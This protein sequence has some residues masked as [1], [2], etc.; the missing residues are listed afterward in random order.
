MDATWSTESNTRSTN[1]HQSSNPK[2]VIAP[3]D[4]L[5]STNPHLVDGDMKDVE[6]NNT[7]RP[8][9]QEEF[10]ATDGDDEGKYEEQKSSS[11]E[12]S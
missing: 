1:H 6:G 8:Q 12:Q 3:A 4:K 5:I 10:L 9:Q 2:Q 11:Y 7:M